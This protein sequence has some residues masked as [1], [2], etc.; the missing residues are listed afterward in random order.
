MAGWD[1]IDM[2]LDCLSFQP[3]AEGV[4]LLWEIGT[5]V[6]VICICMKL[7]LEFDSGE[8]ME[9]PLLLGQSCAPLSYEFLCL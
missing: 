4:T 6:S 8:I 5:I 7:F 3:L 2:C 9:L 1:R